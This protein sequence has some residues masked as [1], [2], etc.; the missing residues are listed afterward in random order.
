MAAKDV[1]GARLA[2]RELQD[3]AA[4]LDSEMLGG[5]AAHARGA[6]A[7]AEGD[8]ADASALLGRARELLE[9]IGSPYEAARVRVTMGLACRAA[10]DDDGA[11]LEWQA[12]RAVF[13]R[14][15]AAPDLDRVDALMR[16]TQ[17]ARSCGLTSRELEVL[18]LVASGK[19]NKAI[20]NELRLSEKTIDRHV[21]NIFG[22]I[23]VPSRAAATAWAYEHAV[24]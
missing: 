3:I 6:V 18:R 1:P 20:A 2:S 7:L 12:A 15:G 22:K 13:A 16:G 24:V 19:T 8:A 17:P 9:K 11:A 21:S 4:G 10:G 23:D 5:I 14:L